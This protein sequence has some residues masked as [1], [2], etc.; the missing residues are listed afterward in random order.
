MLQIP[1]GQTTEAERAILRHLR[2]WIAALAVG[3]L[4]VGVGVG[5]MLNRTS[6]LAGADQPAATA[7]AIAKAPE[8]LSASFA[9]IARR[10][11]PAVVNIDTVSAAPAVADKDGGD[12]NDEAEDGPDNPLLDMLRRHARRPSRGVGSGF[13]VDPKGIILTNYHVV[14]NMTGIMVKLQTGEQLRGTM[15]ASDEETDIAVIK[16][17]AGR[18][19]PAVN[20]GNSDD[21]QVGD[22]VLAIGSPFGLEQTVTAGIISTKERQT[23]PG[24]SFRRFIQTDA[25]INRGN[26]GGP[27]VNMRGEVIGINSQIATSTGDY[28]GIGFALPTNI[29]SSVYKQLM[30]TG[31]VRRG[32]LGV[33]LDSVKPE[34]ARV[35][36]LPSAKGAIIRDVADAK[37]PAATAGIQTNDVVVEFNNQAVDSAQDL[38]NKV[39]STPVGTSVPV[40]YLRES[41]DKL[42]RR[43]TNVTV[44]ERPP[45]RNGGAAGPEAE[46]DSGGGAKIIKPKAEE[47]APPKSDRPTLGLKLSELTPQIANERNLKGV[48]GLFVQDVDQAGI[49]FDAGV[50]KFMVIQRVNRQGVSTIE[51]FERVINALKAGDPIVLH[52]SSF[53]GER[54]TQS[55]VQ[56]TYQ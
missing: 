50:Q 29:A 13:V 28:N 51:D 55:I 20:F 31:K 35:Y 39:A 56:F 48:R 36:N 1:K 8:A 21:M 5:A 47:E 53:N 34:F 54:V 6:V 22:W 4:L 3:C 17:N 14:E 33:F 27:L 23:D 30:T 43:S 12:D 10:V 41:A 26:S 7:A 45:P 24:A 44:G 46:R 19:L 2:V 9:E 37:G 42:E 16:V 38:I 25:A 18:D 40:I 52:V 15:I 49:A 32:Y 11:E